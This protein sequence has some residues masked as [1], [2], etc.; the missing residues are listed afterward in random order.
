MLVLLP[1][2]YMGVHYDC[3]LRIS[4]CTLVAID[5]SMGTKPQATEEDSPSEEAREMEPE[6]ETAHED[7][8]G[9]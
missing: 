5:A 4:L 3:H 9:K 7:G 1:C 8:K 6:E 2:V